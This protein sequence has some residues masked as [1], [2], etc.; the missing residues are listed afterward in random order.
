MSRFA[1]GPV[2][3][4]RESIQCLADRFLPDADEFTRRVMV[5]IA[6]AESGGVV[7]VTGD[8][9]ES[10]HQVEDSVARYDYGLWQINSQ[11]GF[12]AARLLNSPEYNAGAMAEIYERQDFGAWSTYNAGTFRQFLSADIDDAFILE[13]AL[14]DA[15]AKLAEP[16]TREQIANVLRFL[17]ERFGDI[18]AEEIG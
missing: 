3:L 5:A 2:T 12:D 10:G 8:N 6:L 1:T 9:F 13:A 16:P 4:D 17:H 18:V 11:H 14:R 15:I 7:N